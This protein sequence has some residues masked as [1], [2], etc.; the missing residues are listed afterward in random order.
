MCLV[1]RENMIIYNLEYD[2]TK[3]YAILEDDNAVRYFI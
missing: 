2:T 3:W 1:T